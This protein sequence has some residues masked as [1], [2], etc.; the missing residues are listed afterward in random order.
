[1]RRSLVS[2]LALLVSPIS[3]FGQALETSLEKRLLAPIAHK[4]FTPV[5]SQKVP[6]VELALKLLDSPA[7][8]T[9]VGGPEHKDL[10]KARLVQTYYYFLWPSMISAEEVLNQRVQTIYAITKTEERWVFLLPSF[11]S[12]QSVLTKLLAGGASRMDT[13]R[14]LEKVEGFQPGSV[15]AELCQ[16]LILLH[17]QAHLNGAAIDDIECLVLSM[18]NTRRVAEKCAPQILTSPPDPKAL[19]T[20]QPARAPKNCSGCHTAMGISTKGLHTKP[21]DQKKQ[22]S[23]RHGASRG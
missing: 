5:D 16:A 9:A 19:V 18:L 14:A 11:T 15:N 12:P 1:M 20:S 13:L 4:P 10:V 17:E 8:A 22:L 6:G 2:V 7:C 23:K 3:T 21:R